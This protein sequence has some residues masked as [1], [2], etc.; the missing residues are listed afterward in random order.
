MECDVGSVRGK[1]RYCIALLF[2]LLCEGEI[3]KQYYYCVKHR[4]VALRMLFGQEQFGIGG[5]PMSVRVF[6]M[7][8]GECGWGW[9]HQARSELD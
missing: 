6:G 5:K 7:L 8:H 2:I 1:Y 3:P 9:V 4:E